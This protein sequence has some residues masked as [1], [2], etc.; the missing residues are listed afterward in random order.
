MSVDV[1]RWTI[2]EGINGTPGIW[3]EHGD[4]QG[5]KGKLR[6]EFRRTVVVPEDSKL[7]VEE[8]KALTTR[9]RPDDPDA[10]EAAYAS[11]YQAAVTDVLEFLVSKRR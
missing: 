6:G 4:H 2:Y 5:W 9:V 7:P 1:E 8:I 10:R 3:T 11:G